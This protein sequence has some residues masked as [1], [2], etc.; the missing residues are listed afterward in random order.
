LRPEI[1]VVDNGSSDGTSEVVQRQVGRSI[2][3]RYV[4]EP[5]AGLSNARNTGLSHSKGDIIIFTDD[6]LRFPKPWLETMCEP[7]V[8]KRGEA[9]AGNVD[10][11]PHL[12][13][14][15][16]T[17]THRAWLASTERLHPLNPSEMV[18]AN[19]AFTRSVLDYVPFFDPELGAGASGFGEENLF[20]SQLKIAGLK[21]ARS[22]G[23]PV[24]HHFDEKRLM[25][26]SWLSAAKALGISTGYLD[27]HWRH[28][29]H[30]FG[31]IRLMRQIA[32]YY[33]YRTL[34]WRECLSAEGAPDWELW[35]LVTIHRVS[36]YHMEQSRPHNYDREGLVKIRGI[37]ES[38]Q[39]QSMPEGTAS[40]PVI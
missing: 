14:P 4:N 40:M 37:V 29:V 2:P 7:F 3:V 31:P 12:R 28:E 13:R 21:I 32:R 35:S 8:G 22:K 36:A 34:R 11:A 26:S 10:L 27:Y 16:M 38:R 19:M 15:W 20:A 17:P 23:P 24:I 39:R 30:P 25:R 33:F 9:V 6:D 1:F 18:G 5:R